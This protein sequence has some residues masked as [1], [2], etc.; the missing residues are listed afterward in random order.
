MVL[1]GGLES[2]FLVLGAERQSADEDEGG[3]GDN[4]AHHDLPTKPLSTAPTGRPASVVATSAAIAGATSASAI[5][6][7]T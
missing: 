7:R 1:S 2:G 4:L 5:N 3:G 6:G